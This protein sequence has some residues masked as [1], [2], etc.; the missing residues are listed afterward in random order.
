MASSASHRRTRCNG[1]GGA[2]DIRVLS[3]ICSRS[4]GFAATGPRWWDRGVWRR[5]TCSPPGTDAPTGFWTGGGDALPTAVV[6]IWMQKEENERTETACF[7]R[8]CL[9]RMRPAGLDYFFA[10]GTR[11]GPPPPRKATGRGQLPVHMA[12]TPQAT[13]SRPISEATR[14]PPG[15][16]APTPT[17]NARA[18][19][20]RLLVAPDRRRRTERAVKKNKKTAGTLSLLQRANPSNKARELHGPATP[21]QGP[22][23]A[24]FGVPPPAM[25]HYIFFGGGRC[26]APQDRREAAAPPQQGTDGRLGGA[27]LGHSTTMSRPPSASI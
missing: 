9:S 13:L 12:G 3:C 26:S 4:A 23:A 24:L 25:W 10:R 21:R 6:P 11:E 17:P 20:T 18:R 27:P 15:G 14:P 5:R 19:R 1:G 2:P 22:P 16:C 8:P 7:E